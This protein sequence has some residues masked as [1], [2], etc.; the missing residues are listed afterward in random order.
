MRGV[1]VNRR[2]VTGELEYGIGGN[3]GGYDWHYSVLS[4]GLLIT[5]G[6]GWVI[7]QL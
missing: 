6:Y 2:V 3:V 7:G 4:N 1:R 5:N